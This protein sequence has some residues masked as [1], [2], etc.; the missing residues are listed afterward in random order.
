[1]KVRVDPNEGTAAS[2]RTPGRR[3]ATRAR[4]T[5]EGRLN[6]MGKA[7]SI[8]EIV[9]AARQPMTM[10][11]IVRATGLTKPTAHRITALLCDMG[12][13]V[14]DP[15]LGGLVAGRR[16]LGLALDALHGAGP[17]SVRHAILKSVS[18]E[19]GETCN[20]GVLA[21]A[22]VVYVDRVEAKWPLGLRFE[23]GS[24]VPAH[25]TA[26]GKL[27]LSRLPERERSGIVE[28]LPLTRYTARTI[29]DRGR[30]AD[31]LARM[32]P[33]DISVDNGEFIDGVVCVAVPVIGTKGRVIGGVAVSAP[34]ARISLDL[35]LRFVPAMR[36]AAERLAATFD[37]PG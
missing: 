16:L 26:I 5:D 21:G 24:R 32:A 14:R 28:A 25:C 15:A 34:E 7:V 8:L 1:M 3:L 6:A 27:L 19:T 4:V 37:K 33:T 10:P 23:A 31:E 11:E 29:T 20:F 2:R 36:T 17:R 22:E 18:D 35:A 13:L 12:L 9:S 30:L